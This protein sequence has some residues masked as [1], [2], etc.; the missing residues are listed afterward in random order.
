MAAKRLYDVVAANV[1]SENGVSNQTI[2]EFCELL[3]EK[4]GNFVGVFAA[5]EIPNLEED[6]N[7]TIVV[8]LAERGLNQLNGH[9]VTIRAKPTHILYI[10]P[11]GLPCLQSRVTRFL[12]LCQRPVLSNDSMIQ[13][14]DS[15]Y[16]GMYAVLF[17]CHLSHSRPSPP[18]TFRARPGPEND[19]LCMHYLARLIEKKK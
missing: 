12:R 6:K 8:N 16:C 13:S 2:G 10:D 3:C 15:N 18:L 5:D 7:F 1:D 19:K 9:F 4:S 17:T 14:V 11:V